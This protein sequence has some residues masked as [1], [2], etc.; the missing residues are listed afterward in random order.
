MKAPTIYSDLLMDSQKAAVKN[1]YHGLYILYSL[2]ITR[3]QKHI[4]SH[5]AKDKN[6]TTGSCTKTVHMSFNFKAT[7][8]SNIQ[9]WLF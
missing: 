1:K 6:K 9:Y 5:G 4:H 3:N 8:F 2:C 7:L